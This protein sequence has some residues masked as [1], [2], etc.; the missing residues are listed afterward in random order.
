MLHP[1]LELLD[2]VPDPPHLVEL[3]GELVNLPQYLVETRYFRVGHLDGIAGAVVLDLGRG[4]RLLVELPLMTL[5]R[6]FTCQQVSNDVYFVYNKVSRI[7]HRRPSLLYRV[8]QPVEMPRQ[9]IQTR[10]IQQ[11][12]PLT[13]R[14]AGRSAA[15][16]AVLAQSSLLVVTQEL[17][18]VPAEAER[19]VVDGVGGGT[20]GR[21]H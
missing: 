5:V 15:A 16:A 14:L 12:S 11:Q 19:A 17:N 1:R 9:R 7:T 4:L 6:V 21:G 18:L 13:A 2:N 20:R 3:G 8:H 10:R